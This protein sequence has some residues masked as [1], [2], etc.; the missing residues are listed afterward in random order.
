MSTHAIAYVPG[1]DR[2][3]TG[4]RLTPDGLFVRFADDREGVIPFEAL[5]LPAAPEHVTLANVYMIEVHLVGGAVAEVPWD[6]ARHFADPGYRARSE[7]AAQHDRRLF[8]KRLRTLR[9]T[10]GLTQQHLAE[11]AGINRVT[12]ARFETGEQLPRYSTMVALANGL[13]LPIE[14][15]IVP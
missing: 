6:F 15:L 7:V 5:K 8:G 11:R 1:G 12:I 9:M 14:R 13:G 2:M 4:A 3:L 10:R